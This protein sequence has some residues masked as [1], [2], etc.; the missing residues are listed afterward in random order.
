MSWLKFYRIIIA[1]EE[2]F[3]ELKERGVFI[4]T[5]T[6]NINNN[7]RFL[8]GS[9]IIRLD[10]ATRGRTIFYDQSDNLLLEDLEVVKNIFDKHG[11]VYYGTSNLIVKVHPNLNK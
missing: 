8:G 2:A 5:T 3:K 7:V 11:L 4:S 10:V 1:I 6:N 9:E